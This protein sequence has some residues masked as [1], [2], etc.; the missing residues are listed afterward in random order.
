MR[1]RKNLPRGRF[2]V[3]RNSSLQCYLFICAASDET[4]SA[5]ASNAAASPRSTYVLYAKSTNL[6]PTTTA[7]ALSAAACA[8]SGFEIPKP[9]ATGKTDALRTS[10]SLAAMP[11][12]HPL[13]PP[14]LRN[15]GSPRPFPKSSECGRAT[16]S[17]PRAV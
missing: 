6:L 12:A 3:L 13:R 15:T 16:T 1:A 9:A 8:I 5:A 2:C 4:K 11:R 7:S 10:A 14:Q 17:E